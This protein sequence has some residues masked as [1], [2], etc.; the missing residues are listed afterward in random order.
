MRGQRGQ[1]LVLTQ[2]TRFTAIRGHISRFWIWHSTFASPRP[3]S[4]CAGP[5]VGGSALSA[6]LVSKFLSK[7]PGHVELRN[8]ENE[9]RQSPRDKKP[10]WT[11]V[12]K[13][14]QAEPD[15]GHAHYHEEDD[16][17][18]AHK[19][20]WVCWPRSASSK[21]FI[22]ACNIRFTSVFAGTR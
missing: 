7:F 16:S 11:V 22:E 18:I 1:S 21:H 19:L 5:E 8:A 2:A 6:F 10:I 12:S 20:C 17:V 13:E 4:G 3:P 14:V 15:E 9:K